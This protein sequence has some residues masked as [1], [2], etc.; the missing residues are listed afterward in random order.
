MFT[1]FSRAGPCLTS[2]RF[3]LFGQSIL[4][5]TLER[6]KWTKTHL[7]CPFR[8]IQK[9]SDLPAEN[10]TPNLHNRRKFRSL[11]SDNMEDEKQSREA[12]SEESRISRK[13][14]I[15]Q[16]VSISDLIS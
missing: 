10:M 8:A 11:T 13:K 6:G 15:I 1:S 3:R 2:R 7:C 5:G 9:G 16:L 4:D 14:T 12:E